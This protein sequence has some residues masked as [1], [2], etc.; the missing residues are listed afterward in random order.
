MVGA[1]RSLM[2]GGF[3]GLLISF[4]LGC[5]LLIEGGHKVTF[6]GSI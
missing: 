6:P 4:R 5:F 1:P 3:I 2:I